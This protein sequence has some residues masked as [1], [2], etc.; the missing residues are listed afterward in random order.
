[1][2]RT[3]SEI[4]MLAGGLALALAAGPIGIGLL[5]SLMISNQMIGIGLAT[6][7]AATAGL[8]NPLPLDPS[9]IAPQGQLPIQSPN[10]LW[11]VVY[12]IFQFAGAI[13][14]ADGPNL[15]W[16]G[17]AG[18]QIC[19]NQMVNR[20]YT[21][22]C[23]QIAGFLAVILDGQTF[24]FGTDLVLLTTANNN[25]GLYGPPGMWGFVGQPTNGNPAGISSPNPW[26]GSIF[27]E[28]DPGDPGY[29]QS[30][31]EWL[32]SGAVFNGRHFGSPRWPNTCRQ[33]GRS[34]VHVLTHYAQQAET[35]SW[36]PA[37]GAPQPYVL[38][39]GRL[40]PVEFKIAGRIV[41]DYRI[42]T[43][44]QASTSY[45]E[46][47]YVLAVGAN[48]QVCVFIQIAA[49]GVSAATV[50]N[51]Q[52]IAFGGTIIDGG[53]VWQNAGAP[54]HAA[55]SGL[56]SLNSPT[57]NKLGGPGGTILIADAWQGGISTA[58][59]GTPA[60]IEAPI[61]WLQWPNGT[62]IT[63]QTRP[64]FSTVLGGTVTDGSLATGFGAWTCLGR[65]KYATCLPDPDGTQNQGGFSNPALVVA[66][67]LQTPKNQFGLGATLTLDSIDS[68][69]A[70]ANICDEPVV[71]EVF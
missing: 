18:G 70:A 24:N 40:P 3:T 47:R 19:Q 14:F 2:S 31:F 46:F 27:F 58:W 36:G 53:C 20:V 42:V 65:S 59:A 67:Y 57:S 15:D 12:G 34:K 49:P 26:I 32:S 48:G 52:S 62:F 55:G 30:P 16:Q 35:L 7:M 51:F 28:F 50:P 66:D 44:W 25:N 5:G 13:T 37:A 64:N 33:Q 4:G 45:V 1:M 6:A 71:I 63:G 10:P 22:T 8:L 61:G 9:N 69:I 54:F 39:G 43:A 68:V 29:T 56:T 11:R 21:L 41:L 38:G 17:S 23:H 60:V